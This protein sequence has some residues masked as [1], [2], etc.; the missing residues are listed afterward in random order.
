MGWIV[1]GKDGQGLRLKIGITDLRV[2]ISHDLGVIL[3]EIS[4]HTIIA[5]MAFIV[6]F[7]MVFC[8]YS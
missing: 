6:P 8:A 7:T 3:W 4:G 5:M 1:G 2:G